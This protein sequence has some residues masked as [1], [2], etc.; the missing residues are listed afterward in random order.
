[1]RE[2]N[3]RPIGREELGL[4]SLVRLKLALELIVSDVVSS[5]T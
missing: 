4:L 3:S 2:T 5:D 1:V